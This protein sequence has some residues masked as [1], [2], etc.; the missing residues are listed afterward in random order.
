MLGLAN[1]FHFCEHEVVWR[2]MS[3]NAWFGSYRLL[4][5]E[6]KMGDGGDVRERMRGCVLH[7]I[8]KDVSGVY[9]L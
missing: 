5:R 6:G 1:I 4:L 3:F 9:L 8:F 2:K 7:E